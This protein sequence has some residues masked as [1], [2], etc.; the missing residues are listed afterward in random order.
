MLAPVDGTDWPR[1]DPTANPGRMIGVLD[2]TEHRS[3]FGQI[4]TCSGPWRQTNTERMIKETADG[5][6]EAGRC[7]WIAQKGRGTRHGETYQE[8]QSETQIRPG[9]A[10]RKVGQQGRRNAAGHLQDRKKNQGPHTDPGGKRRYLANGFSSRGGHSGC[11]K[12]TPGAN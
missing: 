6:N 12:T 1:S 11:R 9:G 2:A 10:G 3:R 7:H 4:M 5:W 8:R